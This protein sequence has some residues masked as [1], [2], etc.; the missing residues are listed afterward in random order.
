MAR[1]WRRAPRTAFRRP[2]DNGA[3]RAMMENI[4]GEM[5][6]ATRPRAVP[7]DARDDLPF[8]REAGTKLMRYLSNAWRDGHG[9]RR[10]VRRAQRRFGLD[11]HRAFAAMKAAVAKCRK[12]EWRV[13]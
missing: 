13:S 12:N 4:D 1:T 7:P 5:V 3:R 6:S 9:F 11:Y 8:S 2:R 10:M